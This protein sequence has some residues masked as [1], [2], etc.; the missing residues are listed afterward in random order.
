MDLLLLLLKFPNKYT[1][2]HIYAPTITN[3]YNTAELTSQ[4]ASYTHMKFS[5]IIKSVTSCYPG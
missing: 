4:N 5:N 3:D 2:A 1:Y